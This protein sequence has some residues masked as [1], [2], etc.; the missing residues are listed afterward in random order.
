MSTRGGWHVGGVLVATALALAFSGQ[1]TRGAEEGLLTGTIRSASGA[2]LEGV[3]VSAQIPG[4]PITT[5]V[6]TGVDGRY[7]FP[8]MKDGKYK[9]WA[10]AVGLERA[11][12]TADVGSKSTHVDFTMKDTSDFLLQLSGYQIMAALPEDTVSHRRGKL[13]LQKNCTYCHEIATTLRDR[14]DQQGWEAIVLAMTN[15]FSRNPKPLTPYQKE[16]AT[17]LT[18]IRGPGKSPMMPKVFRPKSDATLPVIYE[19]DVEYEDGGFS[20]H[21]G[22]DWR[23]GQASTAGGG[24]AIHDAT[25]DWDGNIWFTSTRQGTART[26]GRVDGTTGKTTN[27]AVAVKGNEVAKSHGIILGPDGRVYFNASPNIPYLHGD[28]G[29]VDTRAQKVEALPLPEGMLGVSGWLSYDGKGNIWA[30]SGSIE[31]PAGA[32]KFDPKTRTFTQFKSPTVGMTYGIA[33][34]RDGNGWWTAVNDDTIVYSDA[35]GNVHEIPLPPK[36]L[37]EYLKPGD[38][39]EGEVIPQPGLGGKQAPRRPN[40]DLNGTAVW[41]PNFFG[42]TLLRIDTHTKALKYYAVPYPA[43]NP[44]EAAVDSKHRVWVTFQ[45][46]DEMGRFDPDSESWTMYSWPTKGMAQR[47]NHMV[48]RNGVLQFTSAS[49]T[50]HRVG[51]MVIRSERDVQGLRDGV[52]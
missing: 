2:P 15:G 32:V 5:S 45:N 9:M 19:Y 27:F 8:P 52:R 24:G 12:G 13:L 30:A 31:P 46:S 7:F 22:S 16:L 40:A 21:N 6:F 26:I 48:E 42:N 25:L 47:Q 29:I 34:D 49:G 35:A 1:R 37:A 3:A 44:Y 18:E 39:A 28:L 14:F 23:F 20:A 17:Y 43:M 51:R 10:Q 38:F 4:I 36:P 11:E 33:G 41:V 50:S